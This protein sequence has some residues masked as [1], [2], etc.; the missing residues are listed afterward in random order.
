ME[1]F[2]HS[3]RGRFLL[4]LS[5][6]DYKKKGRSKKMAKGLLTRKKNRNSICHREE[7]SLL[8]LKL[9]KLSRNP[10]LE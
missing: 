5:D 3:Q 8:K 1:K 4:Q 9:P 6:Q 2:N 10:I 7:N